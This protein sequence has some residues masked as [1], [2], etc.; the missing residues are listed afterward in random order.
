M[1]NFKKILREEL[2]S[3][4]DWAKEVT[5][6]YWD[7]FDSVE[8]DTRITYKDFDDFIDNALF[9]K[10]VKNW[11]YWDE[12]SERKVAW[13]YLNYL[14]QTKG[15]ACVTF[16]KQKELIVSSKDY[17]QSEVDKDII[18]NPKIIKYVGVVKKLDESVD[19]FD[20]ARESRLTLQD[21]FDSAKKGESSF[22]VG[23]EFT[24]MGNLA[25]SAEFSPVKWTKPFK[26]TIQSVG[27][28]LEDS[29]FKIAV[30]EK[31]AVYNMEISLDPEKWPD[32]HVFKDIQFVPEDE[33]LLVMSQKVAFPEEEWIIED[34]KE[35]ELDWIK[36][37]EPR[38][39]L[40]IG[41][42]LT[43]K[44]YEEEED[45][46]EDE[47]GNMVDHGKMDW[48]IIGE[49]IDEYNDKKPTFKMVATDRMGEG[50]EIWME[51]EKVKELYDR[52]VYQPC[53]KQTYLKRIMKEEINDFNWVDS[54]S[55]RPLHN[56]TF[57]VKGYPETLYTI[58]DSGL[59]SSVKIKWR[60][61]VG[62]TM[63]GD[64]SDGVEEESTYM[65]DAVNKFFKIGEWIPTE[66][67]I[68]ESSDF[69]WTKDK[70][71]LFIENDILV[72]DLPV[73]REE[74]YDYIIM[75]LK[76]K[77]VN[78]E[79]T[80]I[81]MES[82]EKDGVN[83]REIS[84]MIKNQ[85]D[86]R[87]PY[88]HIQ[89]GSE[90]YY[91]S[92]EGNIIQSVKNRAAGLG[93]SYVFYS[94]LIGNEEGQINE[95]EVETQEDPQKSLYMDI[96][97]KY[98]IERLSTPKIAEQLPVSDLRVKRIANPMGKYNKKEWNAFN[99][100]IKK[101]YGIDDKKLNLIRLVRS[102]FSTN[103]KC[104]EWDSNK[105][106]YD[107]P[108]PFTLE[109]L[110]NYV[111]ELASLPQTKKDSAYTNI[112]NQKPCYYPTTS[113][114]LYKPKIK[115]RLNFILSLEGCDNK[116]I[117]EYWGLLEIISKYAGELPKPDD[118]D[119]IDLVKKH[120]GNRIK[121]INDLNKDIV[122]RKWNMKS[123]NNFIEKKEGKT[124]E[125][126]Q[127]ILPKKIDKAFE[128]EAYWAY[129]TQYFVG[130][131]DSEGQGLIEDYQVEFDNSIMNII[132]SSNIKD[133]KNVCEGVENFT[134]N[135]V[136]MEE[137]A[138]RLANLVNP[139]A[140]TEKFDIKCIKEIQFGGKSIINVGDYLDVKKIREKDSVLTELA[141][142]FKKTSFGEG[143]VGNSDIQK[144]N[145][146]LY[147]EIYNNLIDKLLN[148]ITKQLDNI[149]NNILGGS[150]PFKGLIIED[151]TFV[152]LTSL[153]LY[154]SNKGVR[155]D[156]RIAL[157]YKING[158][159]Y[160][161]TFSPERC[162]SEC[163]EEQTYEVDKKEINS[164]GDYKQLTSKTFNLN[165]N[166]LKESNIIKY[167][168]F[169]K[170]I[171]NEWRNR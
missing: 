90:L 37:V 47:Y 134:I 79:F 108:K 36:D 67:P 94:Q 110:K 107:Y 147:I 51:V 89:F 30:K 64:W 2:D 146:K 133:L 103:P 17:I 22:E 6:D 55:D 48:H 98:F 32:G 50:R 102:Y 11:D 154:W 83:A 157:R 160:R 21:I 105:K 137:E 128:Y 109:E 1:M 5:N 40:K 42:C 72:F 86:G 34:S 43:F 70:S 61:N 168:D 49:F 9:S 149:K 166:K 82:L 125:I 80:K 158:P 119:L 74:L 91:G 28:T 31:E 111:E 126:L 97:S 132:E 93:S 167:S 138:E 13:N 92:F 143:F 4:F 159:V 38:L 139:N 68:T 170:K 129:D 58:K 121:I 150:R 171:N 18:K 46:V 35:D 53:K 76:S 44:Q 142:P 130:E 19:D 77:K 39:P 95:D 54:Q 153:D 66:G 131:S 101:E 14:I 113:K 73:S 62:F 144:K 7:Y 65:R 106:M 163:L 25:G 29:K 8:F 88:L 71:N 169:N 59:R 63:D 165:E 120:N 148:K 23:D 124:Q 100:V 122:G 156:H 33:N 12:S 141:T 75:A 127:K 16:T 117:D 45:W 140:F 116:C 85:E 155:S 69:D 152:P 99:D 136:T 52:G 24:L 161:I 115:E 3:D 151:N 123:F 114:K 56:V 84:Q 162:G 57:K 15:S 118:K 60:T 26:I 164:G 112:K 104:I 78:D 145:C 96:F 135:D 81:W 27:P 20:W 10:E 41:T 87:V